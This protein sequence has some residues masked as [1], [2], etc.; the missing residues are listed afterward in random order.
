MDIRDAAYIAYGFVP[1]D[2]LKERESD[3]LCREATSEQ[4]AKEIEQETRAQRN[5]ECAR[6]H[7]NGYG[8]AVRDLEGAA[9]NLRA[10]SRGMVPRS[11]L[12]RY[13]EEARQALNA[14]EAALQ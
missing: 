12:P 5:E 13:I 2:P 6:I 8:L 1:G 10:Y 14:I 7:A 3:V 4:R 11:C 9:V